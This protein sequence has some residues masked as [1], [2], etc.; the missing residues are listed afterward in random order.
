VLIASIMEQYN[1]DAWCEIVERVQE[2]GVDGLE[3]NLSCPHGLPEQH[4]GSAMGQDPEIVYQVCGWVSEAAKVPVW[5]K[6]TPNV[7]DIAE[8]GSAALSG[9]CEGLSAINTILC[10]MGVNLETLR[11]EPT[12]AG[13]SEPGGYSSVAIR[14][15]SLRMNME[16]ARMMRSD[17]PGRSLVSLGGIETGDDAVQF[18]LIGAHAVQVCTGVMKHGYGLV[19]PM[20]EQLEAFMSKHGFETIDAFRGHSLSYFTTH[21]DLVRRHAEERGVSALHAISGNGSKVRADADWDADAFVQQSA[22]LAGD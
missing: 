15:I 14:P 8:P 17:F 1:R 3:L 6:L 13:Y 22:E 5:A 16:L 21:A 2:T 20:L 18:M 19:K 11:P 10:V 9:G 4:M 7:T 12:V